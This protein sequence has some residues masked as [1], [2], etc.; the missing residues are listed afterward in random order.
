MKISIPQVKT[1][2]GL[3]VSCS[4]LSVG[5]L[6]AKPDKG[7]GGP[8]GHS[9]KGKDKDKGNKGAKDHDKAEK[10]YRK[11]MEKAQKDAEKRHKEAHKDAEKHDKEVAKWMEKRFRDNDRDGVIR[12]FSEYK[13]REHGLPPGLEKNLRRGKPMPPGWRDKLS[14][15]YII[16][17][18]Y[19]DY[20]YPLSYDMFPGLEVV[21][22]TR[23]YRYGD[24]IVRVYEPR[25]EVIDFFIVP[26]LRF[27]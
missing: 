7:K 25:R 23:L 26:T 22:D 16:E 4:L 15:G 1:V 19:L 12:Y 6:E 20:Y 9:E 3:A 8:P 27:D 13:D 10:E 18:D 2:L 21:P 5:V 24:R 14:R 17:D 11:D